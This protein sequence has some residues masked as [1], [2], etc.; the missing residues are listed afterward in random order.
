M[1][2]LKPHKIVAIGDIHCDY[3]RLLR[4]LH[5]QEILFLANL[6]GTQKLM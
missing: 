6:S 1:S 4:I 3:Y 5:E 2:N